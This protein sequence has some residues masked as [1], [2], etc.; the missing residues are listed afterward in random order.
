MELGYLIQFI[1]TGLVLSTS[2]HQRPVSNSFVYSTGNVVPQLVDKTLWWNGFYSAMGSFIPPIVHNSYIGH[3]GEVLYPNVPG[4]TVLS[5]A[6]PGNGVRPGGRL[7]LNQCAYINLRTGLR[8]R[9]YVGSKRIAP[10]ALSDVV[11]DELFIPGDLPWLQF[12]AQL[13]QFFVVTVTG[14]SNVTARPV[15]WSRRLSASDLTVPPG[16]GGMI[17]DGHVNRT[18]GQWK[19]RRERVVR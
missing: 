4:D 14:G 12:L 16:V 6:T 3:N 19:H 10:I 13:N 18:L 7:P 5:V 15:V 8:G 9:E 11:G 2:G 17:L 1:Q